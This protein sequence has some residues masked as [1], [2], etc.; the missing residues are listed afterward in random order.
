MIIFVGGAR[1]LPSYSE[2]GSFKN[3]LGSE[4]SQY[5]IDRYSDW[6]FLTHH[7]F[8]YRCCYNSWVSIILSL[9]L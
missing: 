9:E 8:R 1:I 2:S 5:P 7:Q 4:F 6:I 3:Y